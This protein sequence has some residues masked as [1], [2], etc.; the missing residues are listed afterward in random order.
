ME[1]SSVWASVEAE[2]S[3]GDGHGGCRV[4]VVTNCVQEQN[5]AL[6]C[7]FVLLMHLFSN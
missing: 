5:R 3:P 1:M 7:G 2:A 6:V 4:C